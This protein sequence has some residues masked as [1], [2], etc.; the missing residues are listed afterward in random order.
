MPDLETDPAALD[1]AI[2]RK[3]EFALRGE[4]DRIEGVALA[5]QVFQHFEEILPDEMLQHEAVVQRGAPAHRLAV[6]RLAP[7]P[8]DQRAQQE[9][10]RE[11]MRASG[12]ISND[13]N[14]TR[15]SRPVG[16][17]GE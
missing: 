13:R 4:P 5:A 3:A 15:P 16:P 1:R 10:L 12:G 14:S 11:D 17:S 6:E 7:E 2:E 9:L 8:R